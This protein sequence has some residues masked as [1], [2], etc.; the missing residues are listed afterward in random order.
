MKNDKENFLK[1]RWKDK[2]EMLRYKYKKKKKK[3]KEFDESSGKT[4]EPQEGYCFLDDHFYFKH[5]SIISSTNW[6]I[7]CKV[8]LGVFYLMCSG[9]GGMLCSCLKKLSRSNQPVEDLKI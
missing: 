1:I 8:C 4:T 7:Q 2:I 5:F 3:K 9:R 6:T